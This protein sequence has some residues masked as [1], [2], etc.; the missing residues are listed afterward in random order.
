MMADGNAELR[1]S[2]S[3]SAYMRLAAGPANPWGGSQ[4]YESFGTLHRFNGERPEYRTP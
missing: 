1:R 4:A 2:P 3:T